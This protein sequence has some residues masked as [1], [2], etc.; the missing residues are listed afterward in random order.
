MLSGSAG[1][2]SSGRLRVTLF[3]TYQMCR[4]VPHWW[5]FQLWWKLGTGNA[6][7]LYSW[8]LGPVYICCDHQHQE[9]EH[10]AKVNLENPKILKVSILNEVEGRRKSIS[11]VSG[12]SEEGDQCYW[13]V[14]VESRQILGMVYKILQEMLLERKLEITK[15]GMW[16]W[17]W[18][19]VNTMIIKVLVETESMLTSSNTSVNYLVI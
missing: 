19:E 1:T 3:P 18:R 12:R 2:S 8:W 9:L 17:T 14:R 7:H 6:R 5:W 13:K 15:T 16:R 4:V 10:Y 11:L